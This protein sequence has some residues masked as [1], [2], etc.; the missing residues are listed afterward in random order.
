MP[1]TTSIVTGETPQDINVTMTGSEV[2]KITPTDYSLFDFGTED[3]KQAVNKLLGRSPNDVYMNLPG[4][5]HKLFE[6]YNWEPVN[7]ELAPKSYKIVDHSKQLLVVNTATV[8]NSTESDGYFGSSLT[9]EKQFTVSS[10]WHKRNTFGFTQ[11]INYG[12]QIG[13]GSVGGET[14]ISMEEE[15]GQGASNSD[16]VTIGSKIDTSIKMEPN[17]TYKLTLEAYDN[18]VKLE[19]DYLI[20]LTGGIAVNYKN[21]CK[22]HHFHYLPIERVLSAMTPNKS[23]AFL[24]IESV[25][26]DYWTDSSIM[27][28][29]PAK[30]NEIVE[31]R[32]EKLNTQGKRFEA[33]LVAAV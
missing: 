7:I 25:E 27:F 30:D 10:S 13:V 2:R 9:Q 1:I 26:I 31:V 22:G 23:S 29:N 16:T 3:I 8:T 32:H 18:V 24:A 17:T 11:S 4:G 14:S 28:V 33:D 21:P 20:K 19:V 15:V 12:V 6:R 5:K